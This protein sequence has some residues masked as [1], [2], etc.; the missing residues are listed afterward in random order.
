MNAIESLL[1]EKMHKDE[2]LSTAQ[3]T[4]YILT[5]LKGSEMS[6]TA[7]FVSLLAAQLIRD[8][9]LSETELDNILLQLV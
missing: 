5:D 1:K 7:K 8:G 3:R 9:R 2:G 4:Y 6:R